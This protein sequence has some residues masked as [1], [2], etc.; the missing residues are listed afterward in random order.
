[1]G[2]KGE[3]AKLENS[4]LF[5]RAQLYNNCRRENVVYITRYGIGMRCGCVIRYYTK[6]RPH[7]YNMCFYNIYD[8]R[9]RVC[10]NFRIN[11]QP[12]RTY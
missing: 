5:C 3:K 9:T 7:V 4:H 11:K 2:W 12:D 1:M 8:I 6:A 10:A